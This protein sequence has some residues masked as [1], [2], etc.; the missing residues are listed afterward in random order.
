[1]QCD[2]ADTNTQTATSFTPDKDVD[3]SLELLYWLNAEAAD[4]DQPW[5]GSSSPTACH[6]PNFRTQYQDYNYDFTRFFLMP[7]TPYDYLMTMI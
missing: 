5:A 3:F 6:I 1:M 4:G 2:L 7:M